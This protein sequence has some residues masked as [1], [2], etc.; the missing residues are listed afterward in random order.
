MVCMPKSKMYK[1]ET[2]I[3]PIFVRG[4][5]PSSEVFFFYMLSWF[6]KMKRLHHLGKEQ[7]HPASKLFLLEMVIPPS[8]GDTL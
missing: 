4:M 5:S 6:G 2:Q 7:K 8:R 1:S 3:V